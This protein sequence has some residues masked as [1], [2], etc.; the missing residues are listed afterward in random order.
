M[1]FKILKVSGFSF[2]FYFIWQIKSNSLGRMIITK[3]QFFLN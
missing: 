1:Y 2:I 3:I